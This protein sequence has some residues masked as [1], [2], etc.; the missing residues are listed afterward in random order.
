[1][2]DS[3]GDGEIPEF[4]S[5]WTWYCQRLHHD[6]LSKWRLL[7]LTLSAYKKEECKLH[8]PEKKG[9]EKFK[10]YAAKY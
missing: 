5:F 6:R 4:G 7:K 3:D 8:I 10:E 1:M 9:E 2:I